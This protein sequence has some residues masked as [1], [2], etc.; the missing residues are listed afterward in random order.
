[1]PSTPMPAA[2]SS[3]PSGQLWRLASAVLL[4]ALAAFPAAA[5]PA[6]ARD[7]IE[8]FVEAVNS[9]DAAVLQVFLRESFAAQPEPRSDD[10]WRELAGRLIAD[11]APLEVARVRRRGDEVT[12]EG[13]TD[14]GPVTV[15]LTLA[16]GDGG[17]TGLGVDFGGGEDAAVPPPLLPPATAGRP[18]AEAL[19]PWLDQLAESAGFTGTVLVARDGEAVYETARG[20]A[21][22]RHR[23]ANTPATRFDLGSINKSFTR[24][25]IG[26]LMAAGKLSPDDAV[27][28]HLPDYPDPEVARKVTIQHLL[29]HTSGI[30]DI[31]G[32]EFFASS[33]AQYTTPRSYFPL[34]AGKPLAF[35]PG[36]E[37]RYSN[38]GFMVLGA[39]IEAV[40]GEGFH[41]Y[42][43]RHV[44]APAGMES[45]DFL[46]LDGTAPRVA[47]GYTRQ[48]LDGTNPAGEP[49]SVHYLLP[50][51][52]SPAGSAFAT[53]RDLLAFDNALRDGALLPAGYT[54]WYFRG[55]RADETPGQF[56]SGEYAYGIAGGAPGV[57]AVVES[58]GRLVVIV[59]ANTE[60]IAEDVGSVLYR[61]LSEQRRDG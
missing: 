38:S 10:E 16:P 51:I 48:D 43:R 57:S 4:A 28:R 39:I 58:D 45:A 49:R 40:S 55:E 13:R 8:R 33:K 41:D 34:F 19:D 18:L 44:F 5:S 23:I 42:V 26:Q 14:G 32:P 7:R 61:T 59:L 6:E 30:P 1:M 27:L 25:A 3:F 11:L 53:A 56:R 37:R 17:I 21:D 35:A 15:T 47:T 31:F 12:V 46:R 29:D 50:V 36:S 60:G 2:A 9:G 52:G 20:L 54:A 22:L 24:I